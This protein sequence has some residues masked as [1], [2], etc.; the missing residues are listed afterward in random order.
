MNRSF[1]SLNLK[2]KRDNS[3]LFLFGKNIRKTM[4]EVQCKAWFPP[5]RLSYSDVYSYENNIILLV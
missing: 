1:Q 2:K 3:M 4:D 5:M